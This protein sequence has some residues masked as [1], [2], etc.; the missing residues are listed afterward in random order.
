MSCSQRFGGDPSA[1]E[2]INLA[3]IGAL[4]GKSSRPSVRSMWLSNILV[5]P[6]DA[7]AAPGRPDPS[8]IC[9]GS[10]LEI[11]VPIADPYRVVASGLDVRQGAA[12]DARVEKEPHQVASTMRGSTRS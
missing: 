3:T 1:R 11:L 5:A 10:L 2:R 12:P 7:H 9:K 8:P 6:F 4:P